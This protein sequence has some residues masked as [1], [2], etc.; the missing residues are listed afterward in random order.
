MT[1][2]SE[3]LRVRLGMT[4]TVYLGMVHSHLDSRQISTPT[5]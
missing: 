5:K 1:S 4:T 2:L 3:F